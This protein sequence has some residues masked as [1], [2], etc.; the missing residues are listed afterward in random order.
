[1]LR[2][3]VSLALRFP[4][5]FKYRDKMTIMGDILKS[6]RTS[7]KGLKQ[8]QIMQSANLSYVQTKK[9]LNYLTNVG[10][11]VFTEGRTYLITEKG[12]KFLLSVE[13]QMLH[14]MR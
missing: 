1:M 3:K 8:T 2:L 9:Y 12:S 5:T 6:V 11:V 14:S 4:H 13:M 10:F 7:K